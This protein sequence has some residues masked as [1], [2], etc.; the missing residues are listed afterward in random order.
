MHD[1]EVDKYRKQII[2]LGQEAYKLFSCDTVL[3]RDETC[4][5]VLKIAM[6][7]EN[8]YSP[9]LYPCSENVS[10]L[11]AELN[12]FEARGNAFLDALDESNLNIDF[13]AH[14]YYMHYFLLHAED[15]CWFV[16]NE[17]G[18]HLSELYL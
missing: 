4:Q 18:K 7:F 17:I 15:E 13:K 10:D 16:L 14:S 5:K 3:E 2:D 8:L 12:D 9:V 11:L 1:K 6:A